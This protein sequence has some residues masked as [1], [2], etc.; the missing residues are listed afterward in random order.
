MY[1]HADRF[2]DH[3][4]PFIFVNDIERNIFRN[5]SVCSGSD[6]GIDN[7]LISWSYFIIGPDFFAIYQHHA[8]ING[9]LQ[10]VAGGAFNP[11]D[12]EFIDAKRF[13]AFIDSKIEP[14]IQFIVVVIRDPGYQ[15]CCSFI[16]YLF[17]VFIVCASCLFAVYRE[18]S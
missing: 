10:F 1:Y 18:I 7:D 13:L 4:D 5:Y 2:I 11:V 9:L 8:R 14:F 16:D 17:T 6:I 3:H 15:S 12:Q